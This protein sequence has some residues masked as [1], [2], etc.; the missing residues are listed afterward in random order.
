M[1]HFGTTLRGTLRGIVPQNDQPGPV[2]PPTE[3][4]EPATILLQILVE[5]ASLIILLKLI[6]LPAPTKSIT[7]KISEA[8]RW[9]RRDN[10]EARERQSNTEQPRPILPRPLIES[11]DPILANARIDMQLPRETKFSIDRPAPV[12]KSTSTYP[13]CQSLCP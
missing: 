9:E 3:S 6:M 12:R 11:V 4:L 10:E 1:S 8:R 2:C 7:L 13:Y 5:E